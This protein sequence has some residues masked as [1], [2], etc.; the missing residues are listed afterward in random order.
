MAN[1][2]PIARS[3]QMSCQRGYRLRSD[4]AVS[5]EPS[6]I[7]TACWP[8]GLCLVAEPVTLSGASHHVLQVALRGPERPGLLR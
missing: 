2:K 3:I 4:S 7:G 6:L 5:A 1:E 8:N